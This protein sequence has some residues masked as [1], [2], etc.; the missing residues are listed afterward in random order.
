[1]PGKLK[2]H[3]GRTKPLLKRV[4]ERRVPRECVYRAKE[5]FSAPVKSWLNGELRERLWDHLEP[6]RLRREGVIDDRV[7][8]N[9]AREHAAGSAN[10]S[11]ILWSL[12]VFQ[13]WRDRWAV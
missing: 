5:G 9:L 12:L 3:H 4:A 6:A 2:V 10:H 1:M 7:A 13:D 8:A 11:H